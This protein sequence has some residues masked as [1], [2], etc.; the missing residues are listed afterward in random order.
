MDTV[1]PNGY[2]VVT[3]TIFPLLP[4]STCELLA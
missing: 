1:L 4:K 2:K 3:S